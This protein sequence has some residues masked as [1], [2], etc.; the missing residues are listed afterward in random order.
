MF[1]NQQSADSGIAA[2]VRRD[3]KN[4]FEQRA[5]AIACGEQPLLTISCLG[6][7]VRLWGEWYALCTLCA[8]M[9]RVYPNNR[10]RG[11]ICCNRC[12]PKMLGVED[13][14]VIPE[15][16]MK[17]PTCRFCGKTD[18]ERSGARWKLVKAPRDESGANSHLPPSL[19]QV[20]Y[21][22]A[23]YR[24]W[25]GNAH[26]S[27][28]TRVIVSHLALGAKPVWGAEDTARPEDRPVIEGEELLEP[29][30]QPRKRRRR[31]K[32]APPAEA[33]TSQAQD[34]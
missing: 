17:T 4:A 26:K 8:A 27:L 32:S 10:F 1:A 15:H 22:P 31:R 13:S 7:A 2:R 12:D 9:I 19:R 23:H 28:P 16:T 18:P 20:W 30:A 24:S 21:C 29:E 33:S 34:D 3:A 5:S 25:L 11:D 14:K 6:R